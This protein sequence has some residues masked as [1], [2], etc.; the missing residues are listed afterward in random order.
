[1]DNELE[2]LREKVAL[3][4]RIVELERLLRDMREAAPKEPWYVPY[5]VTPP[6]PWQPWV[7]SPTVPWCD[8][9]T[10]SP[11]APIPDGWMVTPTATVTIC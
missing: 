6:Q 11:D 7:V 8:S 2:H 10:Y 5:P 1:M 9:V 4:E 3:L